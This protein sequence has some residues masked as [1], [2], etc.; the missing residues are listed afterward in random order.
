M[1]RPDRTRILLTA[2]ALISFGLIVWGFRD[3]VSGD[4]AVAKPVAI[5]RLVPNPGDIVLRQSQIGVDLANGY[6]GELTID[7]QDIPTYDLAPSG[8]LCSPATQPFS[9][10]DSIFDPGEGTVYF[11]P[12]P[13]STIEKFAP[14]SHRITVRFWKLCDDK[15]T[16]TSFTWSFKVS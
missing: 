7:G 16:A 9:G 5:D 1:R 14:G 15:A 13:T 8:A 11:T 6:R 4:K 2:A 12:G 10:R 3:G